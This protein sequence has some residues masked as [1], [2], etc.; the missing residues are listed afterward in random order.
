M[1]ILKILVCFM[2]TIALVGCSNNGND[3]I[4]IYST[5][6]DF[7]NEF[8]QKKL[9]EKFP[10][11]DV[12]IQYVSTGNCAAKVKAE[13]KDIEADIIFEMEKTYADEL[14][15]N[16]YTLDDYDFSKYIDE[17]VPTDKKYATSIRYSAAVILNE[18]VLKDRKVDVPQTY[19]DLLDPK[20]KGLISMPSP[21]ASGTGYMILKNI[22]NIMGEEK[23]IAY[24][25]ELSKNILQYTSSGSGPVNALVQGEVGIGLGMTFQ[26]VNEINKGSQLT[27]QFFDSGAPWTSSTFAIVD[28][29]QD[30]KGVKE[31]FQYFFDELI[32]L[33][34][35][36]FLP[37]TIYKNQD[38]KIKNYPEN[39]QYGDMSNNTPEER[40]KLLNKWKY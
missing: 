40:E 12:E 11:Y 17:L 30:K 9:D 8:L 16:F 7:R 28:G 27:I 24:F 22:I 3:K 39:I 2:L 25:D 36:N 31:V 32:L 19:E 13:G 18:Q 1:K 23:G 6:E 21:K 34:K 37:E 10:D 20:Y 29:H 33:D 14:K 5:A 15:D 38:T 26:A 35:Q 4:V